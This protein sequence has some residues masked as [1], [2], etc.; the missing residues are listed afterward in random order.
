MNNNEG[1]ATSRIEG[2]I[3]VRNDPQARG[4]QPKPE[5]A[6]ENYMVF[7]CIN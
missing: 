1:R 2:V 6:E 4:V 3:P 5:R 7:D